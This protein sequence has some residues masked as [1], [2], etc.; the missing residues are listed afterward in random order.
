MGVSTME[1]NSDKTTATREQSQ[2]YQS[3]KNQEESREIYHAVPVS[4]I[5]DDHDQ[6][7]DHN[8]RVGMTF[9]QEERRRQELRLQEETRKME[10]FKRQEEVRK[11]EFVRRQ[12]EARRLEELRLQEEARRQQEERKRMEEERK[13]LGG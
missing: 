11:Q 9:Q 5:Q 6:V 2:A 10:E 4:T 3:S 12:E 8:A 7:Y 1:K 13:K